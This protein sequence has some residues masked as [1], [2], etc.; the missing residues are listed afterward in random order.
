MSR[1][2]LLPRISRAF[3]AGV[4]LLFSS[5]AAQA[6]LIDHGVTY[7]LQVI[8]GL[9]TST[10]NFNLRISG[11]NGPGDTEGGRFGVDDL[12]FNKPADFV[13]ASAAGFL[14]QNGGLNSGGCN[15]SGNFFCFNGAT[16]SG[17]ALAPGS[18]INIAFSV[19]LSPGSNFLMWHPDIKL[20]WEGTKTGNYDNVSKLIDISVAPVPGPVVGAGL[21]GVVMAL[22]GLLAW[23]RRRMAAA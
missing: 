12:A 6:V 14:T 8:S 10:A 16:P 15:G 9:N 4:A 22:G 7:D 1:V 3:V 23:R 17:P 20:D 13:S 21:P 19:T 18:I 5:A 11:I 2:L